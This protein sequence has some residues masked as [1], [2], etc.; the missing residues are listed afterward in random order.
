MRF[1][2]AV[3]APGRPL[4][5]RAPVV[6]Q[7]LR[8]GGGAVV[9]GSVPQVPEA[10][11][12]VA[13]HPGV[14]VLPEAGV[15]P[16]SGTGIGRIPGPMG[17]GGLPHHP[18]PQEQIRVLH[19]AGHVPG[20]AVPS[21]DGGVVVGDVHM[22]P[23]AVH[24]DLRPAMVDAGGFVGHILRLDPPA[25]EQ[26]VEGVGV[27]LADGG[28]LHQGTVGVPGGV[29]QPFLLAELQGGIVIGAAGRQP[30]VEGNHGLHLG[31]A[32]R[33]GGQG[34]IHRSLKD[35]NIRPG[36]GGFVGEVQDLHLP[37]HRVE[38]PPGADRRLTL[39]PEQLRMPL[40]DREDQVLPFV[41]WNVIGRQVHLR[42]P[43][44]RRPEDGGLRP[45]PVPVVRGQGGGLRSGGPLLQGCGEKGP[46]RLWR[47]GGRR[48]GDARRQNGAQ[49]Q[50]QDLS[51]S[52]HGDLS[53]LPALRSPPGGGAAQSNSVI[54]YQS[55]PRFPIPFFKNR[56]RRVSAPGP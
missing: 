11:V 48:Q 19:P 34:L 27:A 8:P 3:L 22:V 12:P 31:Q 45:R 40:E 13:D 43:V 54:F 37:V 7:G 55:S 41:R 4:L 53:F 16:R 39:Q 52:H 2:V 38:V 17:L 29:V 50:G 46:L 42:L 33:H 20:H 23:Q 25:V 24:P 21:G 10:A 5:P 9:Q 35:R 18:I 36:I 14:D 32:L 28:L 56:P 49:H 1:V 6:R 47:G 51:D 15:I 30:V 44:L 26:V